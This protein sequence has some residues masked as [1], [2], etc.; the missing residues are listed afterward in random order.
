MP[1]SLYPRRG[2]ANIDGGDGTSFASPEVEQGRA[3]VCPGASRL[4]NLQLTD[5][6]MPSELC[7]SDLTKT[8]SAQPIGPFIGGVEVSKLF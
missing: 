7:L 5:G 2:R 4:L 1:C 8:L 6:S 3:G